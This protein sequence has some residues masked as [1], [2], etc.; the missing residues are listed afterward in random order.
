[1][2]ACSWNSPLSVDT[3]PVI[4]T[5]STIDQ[6]TIFN[7]K[8]VIADF[9]STMQTPDELADWLKEQSCI[10]EDRYRP[11]VELE[12]IP[13]RLQHFVTFRSPEN[14]PINMAID[15]YVLENQ[16]IDELCSHAGPTCQ[17]AKD[18]KY[19][20][21]RIMKGSLDPDATIGIGQE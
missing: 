13:P 12:S 20:M 10:L 15:I 6:D 16:N 3:A 2:S 18:Q 9:V 14:T 21:F 8:Y 7:Q 5:E 11:D 4:C 19:Q 17:F 1:M